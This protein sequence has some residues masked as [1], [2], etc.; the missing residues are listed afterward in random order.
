MLF[1]IALPEDYAAAQHDGE[2]ALSTRNTPLTADGFVHACA[3]IE[4][5]RT[6]WSAHYSDRDDIIILAIDDSSLED[7]QLTVRFEPGTPDDGEEELF[8]HIYGGPL[9]IGVLKIYSSGLP[10]N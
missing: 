5:V 10:I 8:P 4:Q 1:H 9:P 7:H 6:V 3:S 2:Y